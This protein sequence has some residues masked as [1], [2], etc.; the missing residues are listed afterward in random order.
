MSGNDLAYKWGLRHSIVP[1][2]YK[3]NSLDGPNAN[4]LL[5]LS[6][7]L[8]EE[9]PEHLKIY[10]IAL[11]LLHQVVE[12]CFGKELSQT[13]KISIS[14]FEETYRKLP[15]STKPDEQ[16]SCTIKAHA[17]FTHVPW[18][19]QRTGRALGVYSAQAFEVNQ[20]WKGSK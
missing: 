18:M 4:K 1:K 10:G 14:K 9:L 6:Y 17:I 3:G 13:Y 15:H 20:F 11:N 2:D 12:D 19:I 16:L 5:K 7:E 8:T